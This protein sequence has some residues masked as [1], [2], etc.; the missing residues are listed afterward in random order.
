M[1]RAAKRVG[2]ILLGLAWL[3]AGL[4]PVLAE[5]GRARL[6]EPF[7]IT[8][9]RIDYDDVRDLYTADRHV[10]IVQG[11]RS[12]RARWVTF[13]TATRVGVAEGDVVVLDGGD[14]LRGAFMVFDVDTLQGMLYQGQ[15]DAGSQGFRVEAEELVRTGKNTFEVQDG[16]FS[17]CRCAEGER[18]PW[19]IRA[20]SAKVELGGYGT[21]TNATFEVLGVPV[22]WIPWAFF[23]MKNERE[24]GFLLPDF[25]FG[26]RGG[27]GFGLPFFWAAHPQLNVTATP[28]FF[29]ARGFKQDVELEYVFGEASEG[30]LF[31]AGLS[32]RSAEDVSPFSKTRWGVL[33][34]HDQFLPADWRWQT[35]LKLS[36]D[37]L[38][39]D[40]FRE[41][42]EVQ[43]FRFVESTTNV[44]RDFGASGAYG[45][46]AGARY[47]DDLQGSTFDDSD[48]FILQRWAELRGDVS[49]GSLVGPA[50][51][52][53]RLDSELIYFSG[54]RTA[55]SEI[56]GLP[57]AST[58]D[59]RFF[60][61]GVGGQVRGATAVGAGDGVFQPG[62]P[63]DDRGAR[64]V[65]HPRLARPMRLGRFVEFAPEIGW[66][67]TFYGTEEEGFADRGLLTARAELRSRFSRDF[68]SDSGNGLRHVVEPRLG[69]ALVSQQGQRGNPLFVP[70]GGVEQSRLRTLSLENVTRNPSDRVESA[71]QVV[72]AV[73]QR[74]FRRKGRSGT[75]RLIADVVTAVDWDASESEGIGN[76]TLDAGFLPRGPISGRLRGSFNPE[77]V[78]FREGEAGLSL[79]LPIEGGWLDRFGLSGRYRYLRRLPEFLESQRGSPSTRGFGDSE[80]NQIDLTTSVQ[81]F[82]RFRLSYSTIFSLVGD[83]G[84]I[85][86][87]GLIEYVSRCRCWGIGF[88]LQEESR[89]GFSGGFS[90]R[91]LGLGDE[92]GNLFGDGLGFGIGI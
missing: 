23:P 22:L 72:L 46:M 15:I 37:N 42:Q 77:S 20:G 85:R 21:V 69:W 9:D 6:D 12:L 28:R 16:L 18:L 66:Q 51:V 8:A 64:I 71:N 52:E 36:S 81:L 5:E 76:L 82:R 59:G 44:A 68:V 83:E 40:D 1:A 10:W 13:S 91:F 54:L 58:N 75:P 60:D 63:L 39:A 24:T 92:A 29:S 47:A 17:T 45:V 43:A 55:R 61:I 19:Q 78:A 2:R 32:D 33:W 3:L 34:E 31:V 86:Q 87:Q 35:D 27:I 80:L 49:P 25:T 41:L 67:Q 56:D 73:G 11:E 70:R 79:D 38:Y 14:E 65:L 48:E 88:L 4:E 74:W 84:L 26:G 50:G 90:I 53:A 30:K 7:E 62:E 89:Q 57:S